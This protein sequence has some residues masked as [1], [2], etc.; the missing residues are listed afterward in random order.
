V[1]AQEEIT[2]DIDSS[3]LGEPGLGNP[4]NDYSA[5]DRSEVEALQ[6]SRDALSTRTQGEF[7]AG[8]ADRA[9]ARGRLGYEVRPEDAG[10]F[11]DGGVAVDPAL[12]SKAVQHGKV[13]AVDLGSH[14]PLTDEELSSLVEY[15]EGSVEEA[16]AR[17]T[18]KMKALMLSKVEND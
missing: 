17:A 13:K 15:D 14:S 2:E 1:P 7:T 3:L 4:D 8:L 18:P 5:F 9:E 10:V 6:E 12:E 16:L 11:A